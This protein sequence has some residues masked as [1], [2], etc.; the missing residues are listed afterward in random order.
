MRWD[1]RHGRYW[2]RALRP[3]RTSARTAVNA[4]AMEEN[5]EERVPKYRMQYERSTEP[6]A[7]AAAEDAS[8]VGVQ[9]LS[10]VRCMQG[11]LLLCRHGSLDAHN[12]WTRDAND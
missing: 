8:F 9:L 5:K 3:A 6:A 12:C 7:A 11:L 4:S 1:V 2:T 10:L